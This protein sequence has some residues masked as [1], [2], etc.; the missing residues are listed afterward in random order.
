MSVDEMTMRFKGK[1]RDKLRIT[2]KKEGDGF[3][4][5]ALCDDGYILQVH[6][7]NDPAQ[8]NI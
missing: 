3:Q 2:Y 1:H 4:A 8:K 5:D 6:M 7:R